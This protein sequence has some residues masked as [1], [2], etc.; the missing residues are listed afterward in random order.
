MFVYST[1][2]PPHTKIQTTN[3]Y[4]TAPPFRCDFQ[5]Q[6]PGINDTSLEFTAVGRHRGDLTVVIQALL[7]LHM[8]IPRQRN[9]PTDTNRYVTTGATVR[10]QESFVCVS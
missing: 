8:L 5:R 4:T 6:P 3:L 2:G 1:T 7:S 9:R 10:S